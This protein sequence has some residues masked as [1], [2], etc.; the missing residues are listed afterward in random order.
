M[1]FCW[2]VAN[3]LWVQFE[4]DLQLLMDHCMKVPWNRGTPK[5]SILIGFSVQII[6]FRAPPIEEP[7]Y[8]LWFPIAMIDYSREFFKERPH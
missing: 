3:Q 6:H 2:I 4:A 8:H 7:P 5:S 1:Y